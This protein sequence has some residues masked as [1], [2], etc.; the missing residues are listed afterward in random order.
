MTNSNDPFGN[1]TS[2]GKKPSKPKNAASFLEAFKENAAV[3][4][5]V[6]RSDSL[7]TGVPELK[8][9][10]DLNVAQAVEVEE[11]KKRE[12]AAAA[13]ERMMARQKEEA[14]RAKFKANQKAVE[15]QIDQLRATILKIAK[16]TKNLSWE[17]EKAA[18]ETPVL[19][20]TYHLNFFEKL[21]QALEVIKKRIDDS[22]SWMGTLN[23]RNKRMPFYW[24]QVKK[25]G[26][27]YMMSQ[28]RQVATSAG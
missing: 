13:K 19:P 17:V 25:S 9:G 18:F 5:A 23:K 11:V 3:R 8:P 24:K 27:K 28:E 12:Q 20:G 21:K 2:K 22:A 26:T 1:F 6:K 14:E 10:V 15:K 16:S 7:P 4:P